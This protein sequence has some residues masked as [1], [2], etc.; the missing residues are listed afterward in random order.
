MNAEKQI[1]ASLAG[2]T[3]KFGEI[4]AL[5]NVNMG[6][7][8]GELLAVLG[9]N[10]AGKTTAI[11]LMLGLSAPL[12]GKVAVFGRDPRIASAR[13]RIGAML[14]VAKVPETLKVKEHINLFRSYYANPLSL[15]TT[16]EAAGLEGM[17]ERLF[18]GLSGGQK[19]RVLFALAICGNPDLLFLDE[20]TVGL[21][22]TTRH[23]IWQ[24]IRRL[25]QQGKT[26]V[27]TTHYLEE[28]DALADRV[29]VLNHGVIVAEGTSAEIKSRTAQRKIRC[30]TRLRRAE[31]ENIPEVAA[32][33]E[34]E[35]RVEILTAQ[36]EPVLRELFIL[37][38]NL[39]GL[40]VTNSTLED[41]FLKIVETK[42]AA[43]EMTA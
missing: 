13:G 43:Q 9:P 21:D 34:Q 10:G 19:Q 25:V 39:T 4:T 16:L 3:K 36:V 6:V 27:L 23:L 29:I 37:D 1:V 2:V 18:G 41:A 31:I 22:I 32:V 24:Q 38:P 33:S 42:P 12:S 40:E 17:E 35:S 7:R 30:A 26:V 15:Q 8:A 14:Q 5:N 11:R 28:V 20:P